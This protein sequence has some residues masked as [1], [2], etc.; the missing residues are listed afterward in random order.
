MKNIVEE[1]WIPLERSLDSEET[2]YTYI[3]LFMDVN[4]CAL[5]SY[6]FCGIMV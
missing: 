5:L 1:Y 6:V 4:K 3:Y 2:G